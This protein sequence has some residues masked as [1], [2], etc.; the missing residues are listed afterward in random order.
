M[1]E[2]AELQSHQHCPLDREE[3]LD[4]DVA[5]IIIQDWP[6]FQ[7]DNGQFEMRELC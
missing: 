7:Q 6:Q 4:W 3:G 5:L 2:A 1:P